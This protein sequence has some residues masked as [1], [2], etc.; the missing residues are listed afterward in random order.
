VE[1]PDSLEQPAAASK[2][3]V[4][5]PAAP[6]GAGSKVVATKKRGGPAPP[7]PALKWKK[8]EPAARGLLPPRAK[9]VIKHQATAVAG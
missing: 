5:E 4:L 2:P 7:E 8:V 6:A 9:K 1:V 3:V